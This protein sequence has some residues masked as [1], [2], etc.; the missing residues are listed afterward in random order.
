MAKIAISN[1]VGAFEKEID[2]E[3]PI[4]TM[5]FYRGK[6]IHAGKWDNKSSHLYIK[7]RQNLLF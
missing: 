5:T 7:M 6:E 3:I 2:I 4:E 1:N